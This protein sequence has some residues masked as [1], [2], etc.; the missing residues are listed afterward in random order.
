VNFPEFPEGL[1]ARPLSLDTIAQ[2]PRR[3]E[4]NAGLHTT[5]STLKLSVEHRSSV[6]DGKMIAPQERGGATHGSNKY[7]Y[8][9]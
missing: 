8:L 1:E 2:S 4:G 3:S 6:A 7:F 5:V 9:P